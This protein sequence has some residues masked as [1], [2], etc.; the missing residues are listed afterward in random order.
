M[1]LVDRLLSWVGL[2]FELDLRS[3]PFDRISPDLFL[4][5]RPRPEHVEALEEAGITDVISCLPASRASTVAFLEPRFRTSFLPVRDSIEQDLLG[6]FPTFF[7]AL[8]R[9]RPDGRVLVHCEVGVS[10]SATLVIASVMRSQ[11]LRFFEAYLHVRERRPQV[12]PNIAFASQL[13]AFERSL[14]APRGDGELASLTRYLC[15][16]CQVPLEATALQAALEH[17]D[18]DALAAIQAVF[19]GDIPR[20]VQGVRR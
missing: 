13:Q 6:S 8:E 14:H 12:L 11:G 2:G 19:G 3:E 15:E 4:G 20:V 18:F 9:A 7:D 17:H 5:S 1:S 10:R 16:V